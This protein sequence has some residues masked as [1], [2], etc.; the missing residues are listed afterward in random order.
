M[1][2]TVM[3]TLITILGLTC[4]CGQGLVIEVLD[5]HEQLEKET[6]EINKVKPLV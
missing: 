5:A 3:E 6:K 2:I 4:L 1:S